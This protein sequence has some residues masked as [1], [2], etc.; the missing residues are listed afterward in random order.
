MCGNI[1]VGGKIIIKEIDI[2]ENGHMFPESEHL[3]VSYSEMDNIK[4]CE[5][6][7]VDVDDRV[8]LLELDL[9]PEYD[10]EVYIDGNNNLTYNGFGDKRI[11]FC[12]MC[13]RKL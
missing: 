11:N 3:E 7:E 5:Y 13:G 10:I 4:K 1:D 12:P 8:N 9:Y 6:C 2:M